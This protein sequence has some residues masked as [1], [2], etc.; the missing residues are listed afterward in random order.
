MEHR[1]IQ[2]HNKMNGK[3]SNKDKSEEDVGT[4][5][6]AGLLSGHLLASAGPRVPRVHLSVITKVQVER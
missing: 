4:D 2:H 1:H 3:G 5:S 6:D